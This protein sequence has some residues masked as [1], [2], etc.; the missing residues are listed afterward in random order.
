MATGGNTSSTPDL[1]SILATLAQ[2]APIA[3]HLAAVTPQDDA[4][5]TSLNPDCGGQDT[6]SQ[7][8]LHASHD[9]RLKAAVT[10]QGRSGQ[11]PPRPMIDPSTITAW[12]DALRCITKIAAQNTQFAAS[13]KKV[14]SQLYVSDMRAH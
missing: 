9:P 2:H 7:A 3:T 11:P 4:S 13:L 8:P 5:R 14:S 6:A 10:P 1:Q 12:P